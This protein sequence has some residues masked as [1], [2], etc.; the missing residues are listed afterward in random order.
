MYRIGNLGIDNEMVVVLIQQAIEG[1]QY[2]FKELYDLF[3]NP[4]FNIC[5]RMTGSR[6]EAEDIV[7][8]SFIKAFQK[9]S[10]LKDKRR[11]GA[12]LRKI[13]VNNCLKHASNKIDFKTLSDENHAPAEPTTD[14]IED[15]SHAALHNAIKALPDGCRQI[16]LLYV[17]ENYSHKDIGSM[18]SISESTSKSQYAR[19][20]KLLKQK[21]VSCNG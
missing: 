1:K 17:V 4:M 21:L 3:S 16:F 18:L 8:D 15:F 14:W 2:A 11:F 5:I 20:K 19:A 12:W 13:V 7:Q 6:D 9:L 10:E